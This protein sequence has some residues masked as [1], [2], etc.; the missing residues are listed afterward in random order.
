[1]NKNLLAVAV[2]AA[3]AFSAAA[4]AADGKVNFSGEIID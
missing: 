1:M 4:F 2:L 3:S